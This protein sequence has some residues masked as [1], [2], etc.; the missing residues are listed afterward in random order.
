[1]KLDPKS[2]ES[3]DLVWKLF[4]RGHDFSQWL[5]QLDDD[6]FSERMAICN[7]CPAKNTR[8]N[9][10]DECGCD[11]G[12]KLSWCLE[13]CPLGK[14]GESRK[15]FDKKVEHMLTYLDQEP[16]QPGH[17]RPMFPKEGS[18]PVGTH[19]DWN[20]WRFTLQEDGTWD[21]EDVDIEN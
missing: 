10:C 1:M 11:L 8:Y 9:A 13:T 5:Y 3:K 18:V 6:E 7:E 21:V 17:N 16:T 12:D 20:F 4:K 15:S 2:Q 14:W 19:F